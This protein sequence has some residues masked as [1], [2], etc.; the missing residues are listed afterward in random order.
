VPEV[1]LLPLVPVV[2]LVPLVAL[3]PLVPLVALVPEDPLLPLVP[4]EP[5]EKLVAVTIPSLA[6]RTP[7]NALTFKS[8]EKRPC[9]LTIK[10]I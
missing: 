7:F 10:R 3:V 5:D 8:P 1:P 9:M 6:T 4:L 2:P